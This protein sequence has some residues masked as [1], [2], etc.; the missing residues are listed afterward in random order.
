M[1]R[2]E[3]VGL[4]KDQRHFLPI[5]QCNMPEDQGCQAWDCQANYSWREKAG[6]TVLDAPKGFK[7]F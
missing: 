2:A 4:E 1:E 3:E 5:T 6:T 7:C